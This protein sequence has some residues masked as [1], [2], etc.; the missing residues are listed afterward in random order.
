MILALFFR[1][2]VLDENRCRFALSL[3]VCV[4]RTDFRQIVTKGRFMID[5]IHAHNVALIRDATLVPSQK[6]TVLTGE[7]GAGKTALLSACKLLC[8]E[9]ADATAVREGSVELAV[10]GRFFFDDEEC[11]VSRRVGAD[12]R[13]R[14]SINGSMASVGELQSKVGPLVDLCGQHEHQ[15]LLKTSTH[16]S[17]LDSWAQEVISPKLEAYKEAFASASAAAEELEMIQDAS[18]ASSEKLEEERFVLQRIDSINPQQGEYDELL[19]TLSRA[20]HSESLALAADAAFTALSGE[21]GAIDATQEAASRLS[22]LAAVDEKLG[23][24][25]AS[26]REASY[27]LEDVSREVRNYRDS[28]EYD[29]ETLEQKQERMASLQGLMRSYGP[30]IEDVLVR[31][32]EAANLVSMVDDS[33]ERLRVAE[34]KRVVAEK[35]LHEHA[36]ILDAARQEAAPQFTDRVNEQ[37]EKLEMKG[38]SIVCDLKRLERA[39]WTQ[40]GPSH[41]EFLFSPAEG[42]QP[43]PLAKIAS[44]GEVSR[45]MLALKVVLGA[46]DDVETLIFDEVDAGVGGATALALAKVLSELAETHQVVV[47]THLPQVAVAGDVHYRVSKSEGQKDI[48]ETLLTPLTEEERVDEIARMLSGELSETSK[49]HAKEMLSKAHA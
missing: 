47:V 35:V 40:G 48:P 18:A 25:A 1:R 10:E 34:E 6:L 27:V 2:K 26:L 7:T 39:Q 16:V 4:M 22:A 24:Y 41:V 33:A 15:R 20:E 37:L 11:V 8:G 29:P 5:E 28:V 32:D 46:T 21:A 17:M 12:G 31:R 13:S 9:R 14:V 49:Q 3:S 19:A 43:R 44:G 38:A 42:M 23:E 45:V 36:D 30:R